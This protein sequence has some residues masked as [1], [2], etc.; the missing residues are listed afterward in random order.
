MKYLPR[1]FAPGSVR[2]V[3][4]PERVVPVAPEDAGEEEHHL[5]ED[6]E[7][8]VRTARRFRR[9]RL[10]RTP[11]PPCF[12]TPRGTVT[13]TAS[14]TNARPLRHVTVTVASSS[15]PPPSRFCLRRGV[16]NLASGVAVKHRPRPRAIAL[17]S[18]CAL[19]CGSHCSS[20][21]NSY[22]SSWSHCPSESSSS[23]VALANSRLAR[24]QW[25]RSASAFPRPSSVERR[26][27]AAGPGVARVQGRAQRLS[28]VVHAVERDAVIL[29]EYRVVHRVVHG[30]ASFGVHRA[31][32]ANGVTLEVQLSR[33]NRQ[34]V[35]VRP[36]DD[37]PP[38]SPAASST[39]APVADRSLTDA[40]STRVRPRDRAPRGRPRGGQVAR[41]IS[42]P[43]QQR[44][45]APD[46]DPPSRA[47]FRGE[48]IGRE[49]HAEVDVSARGEEPVRAVH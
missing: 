19:P 18:P 39:A 28:H 5:V 49:P 3:H 17:T 1:R 24:C 11:S 45:P 44:A 26:A 32:V 2:S 4:V 6:A 34:R 12:S 22:G 8:E 33:Q 9:E 46:D 20:P 40:R 43:R 35:P 42:R 16:P 36:R 13:T 7:A 48:I 38:P 30:L 14:A 21:P 25:N 10:G 31:R 27:A 15:S 23:R 37:A 47:T 29:L 41:A